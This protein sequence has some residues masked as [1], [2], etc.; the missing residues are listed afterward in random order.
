[1]LAK[2]KQLVLPEQR[3]KEIIV[4]VV[5]QITPHLGSEV[6]VVAQAETEPRQGMGIAMVVAMEETE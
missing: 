3:V 4:V 5:P 6:G 1:M 2:T